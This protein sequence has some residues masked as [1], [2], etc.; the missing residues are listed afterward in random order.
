MV[1]FGVEIFIEKVFSCKFVNSIC[2]LWLMLNR[3]VSMLISKKLKGSVIQW[4]QCQNEICSS[5]QVSVVVSVSVSVWFYVGSVKVSVISSSQSRNLCFGVICNQ[6]FWQLS[7][8]NLVIMVLFVF[9]IFENVK[10]YC[11]VQ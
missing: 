11:C 8:L 5:Q 3:M 4:Y 1:S 9:C 6:W 7:W 10:N 2:G